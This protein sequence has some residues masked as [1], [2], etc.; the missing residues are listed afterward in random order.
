[1]K[2]ENKKHRLGN[3]A[4]TLIMNGINLLQYGLYLISHNLVIS[5]VVL[6]IDVLLLVFSIKSIKDDKI[7]GIINSLLALTATIGTVLILI[8]SVK[9]LF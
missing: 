4:I 8:L 5:I 2:K 6:L 3:Y 1:M 9:I 7:D